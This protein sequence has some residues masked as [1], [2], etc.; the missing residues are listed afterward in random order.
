MSY[1][2]AVL[3]VIAALLAAIAAKLYVPA[4]QEV[5]PRLSPFTR[6]DV[7]AARQIENAEA[8]RARFKELR[9]GAPIVWIAGG[10]VDA[11][12][13][14]VE[15]SNIVRVQGEVSIDRGW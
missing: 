14:T 15:V 1:T 10:D 9:E 4:L 7:V 6:G 13:S 5:G 11:S 12:G 8:R 2:N 3:T